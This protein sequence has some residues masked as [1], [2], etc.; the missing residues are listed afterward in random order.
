M[1]GAEAPSARAE[2]RV[3]QIF[4][5]D[6]LI[7]FEEIRA[8]V[9]AVTAEEVRALARQAVCGPGTAAWDAG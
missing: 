3:S 8:K 7:P 1:M 4:L 2:A 9:E 6:R 5:R